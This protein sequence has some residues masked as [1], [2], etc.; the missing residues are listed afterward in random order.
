MSILFNC[1]YFVVVHEVL[2]IIVLEQTPIYIKKINFNLFN[3]HLFK[4]QLSLIK[5]YRQ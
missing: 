4:L 2:R 3:R 1:L 5:T